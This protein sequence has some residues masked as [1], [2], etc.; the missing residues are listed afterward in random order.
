MGCQ[1]PDAR[2]L[3]FRTSCCE[4]LFWWLAHLI[5]SRGTMVG[6]PRSKGCATCR[7]R[8]VAVLIS[9][10]LHITSNIV[11]IRG[12]SAIS[13]SRS[14]RRVRSVASSVRAIRDILSCFNGLPTALRR[15]NGSKKLLD[16][17]RLRGVNLHPSLISRPLQMLL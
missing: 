15:G 2:S 4:Q 8:K 6:V 10:D 13:R 1:R 7:R 3:L 17:S 5:N 9:R 16:L 11:L 12:S 14:A